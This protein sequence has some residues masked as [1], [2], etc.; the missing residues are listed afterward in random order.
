L[1]LAQQPD[2]CN[3][4]PDARFQL[5]A[6]GILSLSD[7]WN[8][9]F[10]IRKHCKL[11]TLNDSG[12]KIQYLLL[13]Y[14]SSSLIMESVA[15]E[16]KSRREKQNIS[17][18]QIA[19][20][21][22]ISLRH[23][24][25]L[26]EGRYADL[27]GGIYTRAFLRAYCEKLN[28]DQKE[29]LGR[30]EDEISS[31]A[32]KFPQSKVHIPPQ[33]QAQRPN[34]VLIWSTILL[35]LAAV[36]FINRNWFAAVFSPSFHTRA[37]NIRFEA[38]KQPAISPP[39][40]VVQPSPQPLEQPPPPSALPSTSETPAQLPTAPLKNPDQT[41]ANPAGR[42]LDTALS[43]VKQPLQLE[44]FGIEK[45]WI[46]ILRDNIPALRKEIGPGEVQSLNATE[47]FFII[48]GNAG[49]IRLKVN[50]KS[51]KAPGHSGEV[52]KLLIDEKT[53]PDLLDPNAG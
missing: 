40:S 18:A 41:A 50:G 47:K 15:S 53:L 14:S 22:R 5:K 17:L 6:E 32:D 51:L 3:E 11:L 23:L 37:P 39:S 9:K 8:L 45:C 35:I 42:K 30:Y 25:S 31:L 43:A 13:I 24:E 7:S 20:D 38:P 44:L 33:S 52:R 34:P 10:N 16:L 1:N 19:E 28:I 21:T 2:C 46:S 12:N 29:I 36:I 48:I 26:E 27:P 4:I 49:G